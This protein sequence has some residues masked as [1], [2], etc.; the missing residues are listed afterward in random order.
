MKRVYVVT[1]GEYS[2]YRIEKVFSSRRK[3]HMYSLIDPDRRVEEYDVDDMELDVVSEYLLVSYDYKHNYIR[4][5]TLCGEQVKP[6]ISH[7]WMKPFKFTL[8]LSDDRIYRNIVR[9]GKDS[10]VIMKIIQDKFAEYCY[11]HNTSREELIRERD[12]KYYNP[13]SAFYSTSSSFDNS[14]YRQRLVVNERVA[15]VLKQMI[16]DGK[17]LPPVEELQT[18]YDVTASEVKKEHE[19]D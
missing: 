13:N 17:P 9:Y 18:I 10:K 12:G 11:E 7:G 8:P 1:S 3:A 6:G 5:L 16:V 19:Q 15:T 2:D 14:A 4:E